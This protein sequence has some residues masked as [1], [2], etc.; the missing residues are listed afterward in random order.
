MLFTI[1]T[2]NDE[3]LR[4]YHIDGGDKGRLF[5][6]PDND[7][8]YNDYYLFT[9][10][11]FSVYQTKPECYEPILNKICLVV[12]SGETQQ[13]M[14]DAMLLDRE[15]TT[16]DGVPFISKFLRNGEDVTDEIVALIQNS[17]VVVYPQETALETHR[18][19]Q[20]GN[21]YVG[22]RCEPCYRKRQEE[23]R[24]YRSRQSYGWKP[25]PIFNRA[26]KRE[27]LLHMG[28]EL[29][30]EDVD[31]EGLD[32][33]SAVRTIHN[34]LNKEG[35]DLT[36]YCKSDGSLNDGGVEMVSHPRTLDYYMGR[37]QDFEKCYNEL[38]GEGWRSEEGGHC[39]MHVHI[40]KKYLGKNVDYVCAK[41]GYIFSLFWDELLCISRRRSNALG[42]C[43]KNDIEITD[44][45]NIIID[46][47][48]DQKYDGDRYV[49]VN[50]KPEH[51]LEIRLWRGTLNPRTV[52]ATLDLTQA[53]V[54]CAKKYSINTLQRISFGDILEKM[55]YDENKKAIIERLVSK[56][57]DSR[58]TPTR[59][60]K[61]ESK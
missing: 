26:D 11:G 8:K 18:C 9:N 29:E 12:F 46:K 51:T 45:K 7:I 47:I 28:F 60:N 50:N 30:M 14:L 44:T 49:A 25:D 21:L 22:E 4:K 54:K 6:I 38:V 34:I 41:V 61:K 3:I 19:S 32:Y 13:Q 48:K 36:V 43:H 35:D 52:M 5:F 24:K 27:S 1:F 39:G 55:S 10:D 42:Y 56:G 2:R 15:I 40:D 33:D 16:I 23:M 58:L 59:K 31:D 17:F 20:C 53:I 37:Y 57:V